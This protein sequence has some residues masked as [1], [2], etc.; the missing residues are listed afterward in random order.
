MQIRPQD[1][2]IDMLDR[3][4]QVMVVG[5][6]DADKNKTQHIAQKY[7]HQREQPSQIGLV[8]HLQ[9]KHHDG[10]K[11]RD[12]AVAERFQSS[13]VH[14]NLV[15]R[16]PTLLTSGRRRFYWPSSSFRSESTMLRTSS[17]SDVSGCQP[18]VARAL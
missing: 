11:D 6:V 7:R 4:E 2:T 13:L 8:R 17:S 5:P 3:L 10:D 9:F 18:S 16:R 15:S 1:T 14:S 12:H